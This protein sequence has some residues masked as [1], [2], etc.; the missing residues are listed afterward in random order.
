MG[1][2]PAAAGVR[3]P[4]QTVQAPWQPGVNTTID[5]NPELARVAAEQQLLFPAN[6]RVVCEQMGLNWWAALK[7]Y[8]DGWLSYSPANTHRLDEGQEAELRFV[9]SLVVAGC[10]RGMLAIL[11]SL[12]SKPYAYDASRL[13]FDWLTRCWRLLPDPQA[14]PESIFTDWLDSLVEQGEVSSLTGILELGQ[15]ALARV[16]EEAPEAAVERP[17]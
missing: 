15:D 13:Y 17:A 5:D 4:N 12:L 8:E 3:L 14:H 9:G 6:P 10:D 7:L 1:K 11:L 2:A 16:R